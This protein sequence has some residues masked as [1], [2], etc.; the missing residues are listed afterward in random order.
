VATKASRASH[1]SDLPCSCIPQLPDLTHDVETTGGVSRQH[2]FPRGGAAQA[3]TGTNPRN[4]GP[5]RGLGCSF[6]RT[7]DF[8]FKDRDASS[9]GLIHQASPLNLVLLHRTVSPEGAK[10]RPTRPGRPSQP[11]CFRHPYFRAPSPWGEPYLPALPARLQSLGVA[12]THRPSTTVRTAWALRPN[13]PAKSAERVTRQPPSR[14][15]IRILE[16]ASRTFRRS[17]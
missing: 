16:V 9:G 13:V 11:F 12:S 2:P 8:N 17:S 6:R 3:N 10:L 15:V 4:S 14:L 5:R 7:Y 1:R